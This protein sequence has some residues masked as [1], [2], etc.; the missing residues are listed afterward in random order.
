MKRN[1]ATVA[2]FFRPAAA[3]VLLLLFF[4][5]DE[6]ARAHP[7]DRPFSPVLR[8]PQTYRDV[9]QVSEHYQRIQPKDDEEDDTSMRVIP[10]VNTK[11]HHLEICCLHANILDYYLTNIL[12]HTN[13]DHAQMH[14]LKTNLHRIST[15]LQAHGCNVTQ[16]H[17]HKNAV[18]FRTKLE[19]MEKMKGITK[20]I[21]ELDILFS[22][23]QDYC[24]EPRN[25]TDA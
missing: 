22:Y 21:S 6:Q 5:W 8:H 2:S 9:G 15:D 18:D 16:Y 10:R 19:K 3:A 14:R 17:D 25:S 24:V 4:G 12:H 13:N 1:T 7:V 20:A 23:L 11:D